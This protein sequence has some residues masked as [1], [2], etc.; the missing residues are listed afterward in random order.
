VALCER[1]GEEI[2]VAN[3]L[4]LAGDINRRLHLVTVAGKPRPLTATHW[5]IFMRLYRHGGDVVYNERMHA[6]LSEGRDRPRAHATA[7]QGTRRVEV[8]DRQL[9]KPGL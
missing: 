8:P 7:T 2:A 4:D 6:E 9:S 1:C 5:L 3:D